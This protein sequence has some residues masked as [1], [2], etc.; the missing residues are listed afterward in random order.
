MASIV[1]SV[2]SPSATEEAEIFKSLAHEI[3]RNIIKALGKKN[4]SSFTDI[5]NDVGDIDSPTLS[6][7]LKSLKPLIDQQSGE[8][9]LTDVGKIALLLMNRI[10]QS[11]TLKKAKRGFIYANFITTICWVVMQV[12]ISNMIAPYVDIP[13]N[14]LV[15]TVIVIIAQINYQIIW[16]LYGTSW[17]I[18][19]RRTP[20]RTATEQKNEN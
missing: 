9:I 5:K 16:R 15:V 10:D 4:Q 6:Y 3:R 19:R 20:N 11:H 7:H 13:T 14:V 2:P 8:Y 18:T 17:G 12:I 1:D